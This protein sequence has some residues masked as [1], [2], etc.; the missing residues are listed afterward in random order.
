MTKT[1]QARPTL[2]KGIQMRSRMEAGFAS[3]LDRNHLRWDYEPKAFGG[4]AGQYL[5]DFLI[6]GLAVVDVEH[7]PLIFRAYVEVKPDSVMEQDHCHIADR[8][9]IIH[10][11]EP[12]AVL[13]VVTEQETAR[14]VYN[15]TKERW[16]WTPIYWTMQE[17][18]MLVH[19]RARLDCPLQ[20]E[21]WKG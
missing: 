3:W 11:S 9:R 17:P 6:W 2:Y 12:Q 15:T 1:L 7:A 18:P 21:Y 5:P 16:H 14:L 13:L 4:P 10:G 8:M 20:D 19:A